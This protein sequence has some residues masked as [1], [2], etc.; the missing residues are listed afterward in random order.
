ML[1][2]QIAIQLSRT[3]RVLSKSFRKQLEFGQIWIK[4]LSVN[5]TR[6]LCPWSSPGKNT[7]VGSHSLLWGIFPIQG[8]K[9]GLLHCRQILSHLS[10]QGSPSQ[11]VHVSNHHVMCLK[12]IQ[13]CMSIIFQWNLG[14]GVKISNKE[15]CHSNA[16]CGVGVGGCSKDESN[17]ASTQG[18]WL[19]RPGPQLVPSKWPWPLGH[20]ARRILPL[21]FS[22]AC[23]V[24]YI[25]SQ[26]QRVIIEHLLWARHCGRFWG[27]SGGG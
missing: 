19:M 14:R 4:W 22:R 6:L 20:Q 18:N 26:L 8:L 13:C 23:D 10:C 7:G 11:C 2:G 21:T 12:Q 25:I 5:I 27:Y 3:T 17:H 9:P 15:S 1:S 16:Y 24:Q